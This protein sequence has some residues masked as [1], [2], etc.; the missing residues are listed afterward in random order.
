[1]HQASYFAAEERDA[2]HNGDQ[3]AHREASRILLASEGRPISPAAVAKAASIAIDTGAQ[4]HVLSVARIWGSAF[5]MQHPGLFP[6]PREL[7]QQRDIVTAAI[8]A[9]KRCDLGA[10]GEVLRSR[11]AAK[12][13]ASRTGQG[14]YLGIV[15]TADPEPH[16]LVR[17]LLW[18]HEPYRV[19]RL[20]KVP[21]HLVIG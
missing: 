7:Q 4:V 21:V 20:S 18:S 16:W 17:G 6:T 13:I 11:N 9:L 15:I 12:A 2:H 8:D 1:M 5:G 3:D 10:T 19:R 14:N